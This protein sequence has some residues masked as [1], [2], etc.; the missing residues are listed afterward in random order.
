MSYVM[1]KGIFN[2]GWKFILL[3]PPELSNIFSSHTIPRKSS[4]NIWEI[5]VGLWSNTKFPQCRETPYNLRAQ[6]SKIMIRN[7][8]EMSSA[9]H[10]NTQDMYCNFRS[11]VPI[12][13]FLVNGE[14]QSCLFLQ[15]INNMRQWPYRRLV[16]IRQPSWNTDGNKP[17]G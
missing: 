17:S 6:C 5:T 8:L 15:W 2:Y 11:C 16:S 4:W 12:V 3:R 7:A 10:T 9:M 14:W 1:D 13:I